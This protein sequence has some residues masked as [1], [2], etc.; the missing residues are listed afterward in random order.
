MALLSISACAECISEEDHGE[1]E[2]ICELLP[3][4][5]AEVP[6]SH[7]IA[8]KAARTWVGLGRLYLVDAE[9]RV[10][11]WG[12]QYLGWITDQQIETRRA[13]LALQLENLTVVN[14]RAWLQQSL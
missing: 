6:A 5:L 7:L 1:R 12:N 2:D 10:L 14:F 11:G 8:V 3:P 9:G 4:S 13:H